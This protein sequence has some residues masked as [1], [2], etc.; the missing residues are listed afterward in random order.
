MATDTPRDWLVDVA[1]TD[2][3]RVC[4]VGEHGSL[5]YADMLALV[6]ERASALSDR[7]ETHQIVPIPVAIDAESIV[8]LLATQMAGGV[9]LPYLGRPPDV[10]ATRAEGAAICVATS[11]SSGTPKI[12]PLTYE[13]I[14][15][16]VRASKERLGNDADDRWL[17]CLPLNHVGGLS[18]VWRSL[19]AGGAMVVAPFDATGHPAMSVPC[20]LGNG[21]PIG[22]MLVGKH[23]D[24]AT[25]YRA[26]HAF[27]QSG[28]WHKF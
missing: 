12:V 8:E 24:E 4:L 27:E 11:G 2:P 21:L 17:L 6:S 22:L 28:D 13:S 16:S 20:G 3:D 19:E 14:G 26:A 15:L 9:P 7:V 18:I 25:I 10:L 1:Q 23:W 5:S